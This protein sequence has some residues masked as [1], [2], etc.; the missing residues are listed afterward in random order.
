MA[1]TIWKGN[2]AFVL[3]S[4]SLRLQELSSA[5]Y[6]RTFDSGIVKIV[7]GS[8]RGWWGRRSGRLTVEECHP[9][10]ISLFHRT[11]I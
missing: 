3:V 6:Y 4:C 9:L 11:A 8:A 10:A 7:R 5:R 1:T 2:I